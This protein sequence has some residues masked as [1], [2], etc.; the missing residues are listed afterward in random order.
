MYYIPRVVRQARLGRTT[1]RRLRVKNLIFELFCYI[2]WCVLIDSVR[3]HKGNQVEGGRTVL[4][5]AVGK[6]EDS[7]FPLEIP[8]YESNQLNQ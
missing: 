5:E 3:G 4:Q 6:S 2:L 1:L 7:S 8:S